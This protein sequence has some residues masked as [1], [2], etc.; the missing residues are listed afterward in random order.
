VKAIAADV[1]AQHARLSAALLQ[2]GLF[3]RRDE[4]AASAQARILASVLA[5]TD[6]HRAGLTRMASLTPGPPHLLLA[7]IRR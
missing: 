7:L 2:R 1:S 5:A 6:G 3:D 4:R